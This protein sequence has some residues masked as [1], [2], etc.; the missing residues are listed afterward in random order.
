VRNS[1]VKSCDICVQTAGQA[2]CRRKT[3]GNDSKEK[4]CADEARANKATDL[5]MYMMNDWKFLLG[6]CGEPIV[7]L[8]NDEKKNSKRN[9]DRRKYAMKNEDV[10]I[11]G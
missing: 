5:E 11:S 6:L 3:V 2:A 9:A 10:A 1:A 4:A 8:K 7:S